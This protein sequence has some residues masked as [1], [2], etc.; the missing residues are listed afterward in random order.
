MLTVSKVRTRDVYAGSI[1]VVRNVPAM[2]DLCDAAASILSRPDS[3]RET[4]PDYDIEE[5]ERACEL[6][7]RNE[8]V[9]MLF[10]K[11]I[12]NVSP[13]DVQST[14]VDRIRLRIQTPSETDDVSSARYGFGRLSQTLPVHRDSWGSGID[15]QIN[16]WAPLFPLNEKRTLEIYPNHFR[17]A[18][19]NTSREWDYEELKARR[20]ASRPYPQMPSFISSDVWR[21]R[22]A[23][24]AFPVV[25]NPGDVVLFSGSHLHASVENHTALSR[26]ST[27]WRT[28]NRIDFERTRGAP[29]VDGTYLRGAR[30]E[31]FK[32]IKT[33]ERLSVSLATK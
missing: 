28:V 6:Y 8:E 15:C 32:H 18:V 33:N 26:I 11:I 1:L 29:N 9:Q 17:V 4:R 30:T 12:E 3:S 13:S 21:K 7:E 14:Y 2:R 23:K 10:R 5:I 31:W 22:L 25:V 20:K 24:D 27:E 16:W 19:P